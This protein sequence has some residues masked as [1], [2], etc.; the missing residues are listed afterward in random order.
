[1]IT[2]DDGATLTVQAGAAT[3]LVQTIRKADIKSQQPQRS[4]LMP[5]ALLN[6]LSAGEILDLLAFMKAGGNVPSHEHK[7]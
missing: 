5:T 3:S 2:R 1:M 4:S 6:Q 7:H